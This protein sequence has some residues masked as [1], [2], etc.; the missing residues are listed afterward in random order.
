MSSPYKSS[1]ETLLWDR[2][3]MG[4]SG[5]CAIH[6]LILPVLITL[7]PLWGFTSFMHGWAHPLFIFLLVPTIY[8]A[9]RRSYYD[10]RVVGL[11]SG[12]FVLVLTGWLAGHHWFG[13]L[14]ET[15]VTLIGSLLL[16]TGHW[17]NFKHHQVCKNSRHNHHPV[18]KKNERYE[19]A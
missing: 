18:A 1:T 19:K 11:L 17:L 2:L 15:I 4:L 14:F 6:C 5:I 7:A 12:G 8:Y 9:A 13:F 16:I 3:G 10:R